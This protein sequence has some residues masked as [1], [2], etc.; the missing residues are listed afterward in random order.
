[1][2]INNEKL[3]G[4]GGICAATLA[5]FWWSNGEYESEIELTYN[6]HACEV[7]LRD[8]ECKTLFFRLGGNALALQC[9]STR[10]HSSKYSLH[11]LYVAFDLG[12]RGVQSCEQSRGRI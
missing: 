1:M 3:I 10:L 6:V 4:F 9:F 2:L 8:C 12:N 5:R 7:V 11:P